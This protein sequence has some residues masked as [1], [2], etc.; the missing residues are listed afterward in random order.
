MTTIEEV[1]SKFPQYNDMS[2]QQ[3]LDGLHAKYYSDMPRADF[4]QRVKGYAIDFNQPVDAVRAQVGKLSGPARERALREWSD[5]YVA[6]ERE[7]GGVGMAADNT[8]R[9]L[10]RGS[11]VGPF[12]DEVT[13]AGQKA[14]QVLTGGL[15][16]SDYDEALAYQRARDRAVDKDYPVASAVGQLTGGVAGGIGAIRQGGIT[17]GGLATGGPLATW[18]PAASLTG[19]TAQ[20]A[21]VGGAYGAAAGF[22]GGEGGLD[23]RLD[24]AGAGGILGAGAG[25]VLPPV[26]AGVSRAA[27]GLADAAGPTLARYGQQARNAFGSSEPRT[28]SLSAA[29][30][31]GAGTT[32]PISGAEAAAD[33]IIANQL[34]RANVPVSALRQTLREADDA[35]RFYSNSYAQQVMAP[36]DLDPSLQRLAG[37]VYRQQP[38]AAGT[39]RDFLSARQTGITP[40]GRIEGSFGLPTRAA[41]SRAGPDDTPSG[42]FERVK[43]ALRRALLIKDNDFHGHGKTAY[44]TERQILE[45]AREE[46]QELYDD[47]YKAAAGVDLRPQVGPVLQAWQQRLIDEPAPVAG[48]IANAMK[49]VTRALVSEGQKP[50]LERLDKVKQWLDDQIEKALTSANGRQRYLG[51]RLTE[52]KNNLLDAVAPDKIGDVGEKYAAARAAYSSRMEAREALQLGRD[53]FRENSEVAVDQFKALRTVG[54]QKLF[55]LGLLDS[56]TQH[57]G[58]QKRTADVTQ[59]FQNPRIQQILEGVIPRTET[60]SGR[61]AFGSVFGDRPER[62]GRYIDNERGMVGT[63]NEVM[64]NSATAQRLADDKALDSMSSIIEQMRQTPTWTALAMKAVQSGLDRLFGFR[65]DTAAFVASKLFTASPQERDRLLRALEARMGRNRMEHFQAYLAEVQRRA[66]SA[67]STVTGANLPDEGSGA[68]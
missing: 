60:A 22:G 3:L 63:R 50:H 27:S 28:S 32:G 1:R 68:R 36:V 18:S 14:A 38:E 53:V 20:G 59:V 44:R 26:I 34:M 45:I 57:M 66:L 55:R 41:L 2:D 17:A 48:S 54:E 47:A 9:T 42:Q 23:Q 16:G 30:A 61:V 6:K 24:Q 43:D 12:L 11:F 40:Q 62:F 5:A 39:A 21:A 4:N 10:A 46:A 29:A 7:Q 52:F 19:R 15:A 56:F 51:A 35:S 67:G 31:D 33:Q 49:L 58:R 13:A 8:V 25:A 65:A 37:S 64:G